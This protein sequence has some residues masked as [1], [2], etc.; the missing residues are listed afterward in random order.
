[1]W[2]SFSKW[3]CLMD[4]A[5]IAIRKISINHCAKSFARDEMELSFFYGDGLSV[6]SSRGEGVDAG[7]CWKKGT[8]RKAPPFRTISDKNLSEI[9][10]LGNYCGRLHSYFASRFETITKT[11]NEPSLS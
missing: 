7:D 11:V 1:M 2:N 10:R 8:Q 9:L 6:R 4:I 5:L 3:H